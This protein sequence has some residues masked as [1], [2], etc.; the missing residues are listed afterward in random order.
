MDDT[1][2]PTVDTVFRLTVPDLYPAIL[3]YKRAVVESRPINSLADLDYPDQLDAVRQWARQRT[4]F[5]SRLYVDLVE[6]CMKGSDMDLLRF[7]V[8]HSEDDV[9]ETLKMGLG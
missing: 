8:T 2:T 6:T 5:Y 7:V 3:S 4:R 1:I 9:A